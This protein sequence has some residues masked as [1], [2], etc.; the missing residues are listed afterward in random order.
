MVERFIVELTTS[1]ELIVKV[2]NDLQEQNRL[3]ATENGGLRWKRY[4]FE[5][6]GPELHNVWD[7]HNRPLDMHYVVETA[8]KVIERCILMSTDPGDL[9]LDITCGSGT[10]PFVA[11]KWGR[12]W[13][14]TDASRIPIALARQRVLSSVHDWWILADSTEG[15]VL[16]SEYNKVPLKQPNINSVD[17]A[18]RI[19][20]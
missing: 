12:R 9:V 5:T 20:L 16:E 19:R 3:Y 7:E 10:T 11:E 17:P 15:V 1:G 18:A 4:D 2:F 6:P 8:E 13:I 14:A